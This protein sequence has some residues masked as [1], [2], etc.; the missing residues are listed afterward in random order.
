MAERRASHPP[1]WASLSAACAREASG[2]HSRSPGFSHCAG[3]T[4]ETPP[5]YRSQ[6]GSRSR[7]AQRC[8]LPGLLPARHLARRPARHR[9]SS[10]ARRARRRGGSFSSDHRDWRA[11]MVIQRGSRQ[12]GGAVS[13]V[14][15]DWTQIDWLAPS[16]KPDTLSCT[17]EPIT[18]RL[19]GAFDGFFLDEFFVNRLTR[20]RFSELKIDSSDGSF[21]GL[22][23]FRQHPVARRVNKVPMAFFPSSSIVCRGPRRVNGADGRPPRRPW[24]S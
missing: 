21:H 3:R 2:V 20:E 5:C 8:R 7:Q 6:P 10:R 17:P 15:R 13:G 12:A 22:L 16:W 19:C 23:C 9:G 24:P 4:E 1:G 14:S 18:D 11:A